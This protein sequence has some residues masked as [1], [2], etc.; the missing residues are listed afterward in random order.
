MKKRKIIFLISISCLIFFTISFKNFRFDKCRRPSL[1][2]S[3]PKIQSSNE[4][5]PFHIKR[6]QYSSNHILVKFNPHLSDET[7]QAT[8]A[9]YQAKKTKRIPRLNIFKIEV[10]EAMTVEEI[11]YAMSVNP[12]VVYAEPDYIA[13]IAITP[14]DILF[15]YQYSLYNSGESIDIPGSPRGKARADIKATEGWEETRG[16]ENVIIAIIDT[17]VDL[18]H[19]DLES[20]IYSSGYDFANDDDDATDDN[21]HGTQVAGIAA[22]ETNNTEGIAGVAWNC[23]I[24]PLKAMD[25]NGEG[26]YDWIIQAIIWAVENGADVINLSAGGEEES[27]ALEE[28]VRYA[29]QK[30]VVVVCAGGND[31]GPVLYP[32]AYDDYCMAVAATDY[33]DNRTGWSNFGPEIDVAAPGEW[34]ISCVPT[35][36]W[37]PDSPFPYDYGSGTSMSTPHVSGLAA[38]LKS[39]KPWLTNSEIMSII[40]YTADDVNSNEHPGLDDFIGYGR[41][42]M[43]KALVPIKITG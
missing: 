24:L 40:K 5:L 23:K 15:K 16:E 30:D 2:N 21:G 42:N 8:I 36:F 25:E 10:P 35:W 20:K 34:I 12:N 7:I 3:Q 28:A 22:A 43:E 31:T 4:R 19:P 26:Y 29:F 14:N 41:I 13:Y 18:E 37:V 27:I 39:L 1:Y 17:G 6:Q 32:A 11:L 33:N 38:L 9:A